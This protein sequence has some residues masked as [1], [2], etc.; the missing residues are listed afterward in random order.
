MKA[1]KDLTIGEARE[2]LQ[3]S[4]ERYEELGSIFN[5][6]PDIDDVKDIESD[7]VYEVGKNYILYTVTRAIVGRLKKVAAQELVFSNASWVADSGRWNNILV[8]GLNSVEQS[9][10]EPYVNDVIIGR[11]VYD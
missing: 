9:E 1:I 11:Y 6:K 5:E 2:A 8:N 10:I 3:E 4:R 7:S